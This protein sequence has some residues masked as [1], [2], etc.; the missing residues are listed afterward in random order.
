MRKVCKNK[1]TNEKYANEK[2]YT[3]E[4][5][6][7]KQNYTHKKYTNGKYTNAKCRNEKKYANEKCTN[8]KKGIKII[9]SKTIWKKKTLKVYKWKVCELKVL[10][11]E[12]Q[13]LNVFLI[14]LNRTCTQTNK[15]CSSIG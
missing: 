9:R 4:N 3:T 7:K 5:I 11:N 12:K 14:K 15:R 2:K 13:P 1:K 6:Y 10:Q 8:G